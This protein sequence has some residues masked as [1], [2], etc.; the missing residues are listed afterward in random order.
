MTAG[1]VKLLR[2]KPTNYQSQVFAAS[3][4]N[5][6]TEEANI[7]RPVSAPTVGEESPSKKRVKSASA[8]TTCVPE[9]K[10][11]ED[12]IPTTG[13]S[14][15]G[16]SEL[17]DSSSHTENQ[18]FTDTDECS[19]ASVWECDVCKVALFES[20]DEAKA[21]EEK[22]QGPSEDAKNEIIESDAEYNAVTALKKK[23]EEFLSSALKS[24]KD[25]S[26]EQ[27]IMSKGVPDGEEDRI[28]EM[29]ESFDEECV[30][31]ECAKRATLLTQTPVQA[32]STQQSPQTTDHWKGLSCVQVKIPAFTPPS[33]KVPSTQPRQAAFSQKLKARPVQPASGSKAEGELNTGRWTAEE[34]ERF[35]HGIRTHG[36]YWRMVE[37]IVA[38]R[39][40]LQC[41]THGQK[42]FAKLRKEEGA[43]ET[44][45]N[46]VATVQQQE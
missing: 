33:V 18:A 41:R 31:K 30:D 45:K 24:T 3:F 6:Q 39:T 16:V 12:T 37:P 28:D 21:H 8:R 42:Y 19:A 44:G 29:I 4:L 17:N 34:H 35:L 14:T 11:K 22:C 40:V 10:Q 20:Y 38:T 9:E 7:Y 26:T 36:K 1:S 5:Q 23:E 25:P 2:E 13:R 46:E 15:A 32:P 43:S 27:T